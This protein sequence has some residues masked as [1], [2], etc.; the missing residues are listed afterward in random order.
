MTIVAEAIDARLAEL[1]LGQNAR[2]S[3]HACEASKFH[4]PRPLVTHPYLFGQRQ[5]WLCGNCADNLGV[6]LRLAD[7]GPLPWTI[8][9]EFGNEIRRIGQQIIRDR[10][11]S[12]E[13]VES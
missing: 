6:F 13:T 3:Q 8:L 1:D 7:A 5:L 10:T 9:R 2:A 12:V 11:E 4:S